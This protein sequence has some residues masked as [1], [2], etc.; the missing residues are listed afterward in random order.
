MITKAV[1]IKIV[2]KHLDKKNNK[3]D[4]HIFKIPIYKSFSKKIRLTALK[5]RAQFVK[6]IDIEDPEYYIEPDDWKNS[7]L[8]EIIN[9][10]YIEDYGICWSIPYTSK[11]FYETNKA[12]FGSIGG[13]PIFVDKEDGLIYQTGSAPI[14]WLQNFKDYKSGKNIDE[15]PIWE[16]IKT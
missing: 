8:K 6:N 5:F 3:P 12:R 15:W 1:A 10:E 16:P 11:Q 4:I 13:G 9:H 2:E 7:K 14:D